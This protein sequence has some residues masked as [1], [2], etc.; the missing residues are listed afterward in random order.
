V[1]ACPNCGRENPEGFRFCGFCSASLISEASETR[2]TVTVVFS[3]VTGSTSLGERLDSESLRRVMSRYFDVARTA[4]ERH[5]GTVEKFI[6]DAVVA[7]F[8]VPEVHEDDALRAARASFEL[9]AALAELNDELDRTWGAHL[10]IRT[11]INTGDVVAGDPSSGQTFVSGDAVNVAARLEQAAQP[12]EIL[13]GAE[14]LRLVRDAVRVDPMEALPL[15]GKSEPVRA[16]RLVEILPGEPAFARR[17]D[18]PM[19]GRDPEL[20]AVLDAFEHAERGRACELVTVLG[21]AGVGKSRLLRE[22]STRLVDRARIL[23]GRCLAYGEGITFWPVA[24]IVKQAARIDDSDAPNEARAKI[25]A[26]FSGQDAEA[27]SLIQERVGAAIGLGETQG[28]VQETFWAFRRFL[29][30]LATERP[31]VAVIDDI[32]W[33]EATLLDL[34]EYVA[35][36]SRG[37]PLLL[38]CTARPELHEVRPE[39]GRTGGILALEPL[40]LEESEQLIENLLGQTRL[41]TEVRRRIVESSEGNPLFVEEM[42]RMLIDDGLLRRDDGHWI[43]TNDLSRVSAPRTIQA[44]IAARL[45]RLQDEERAVAQRASV[46]GR[47][48]YWGAVVHLSPE[49][50][51]A[52]IGGHLQTLLR[53]ELILP[54]PSPFVGEDA[55]RFSHILI[56][57]AAYQ[58]MPKRVRTEMHE[59]FASWLERMTGARVTEYE[60]ILGYHLEQAH[61]YRAE[62]GPLDEHGRLLGERAASLLAA[63]G[64]RALARSDLPASIS[65]LERAIELMPSTDPQRTELLVDLG[66]ASADA[67]AYSKAES[68]LAEA[69]ERSAAANDERMRAHA[70][71][72]RLSLRLLTDPAIDVED[73]EGQA[74]RALQVLEASGDHLGMARAWH[75]LGWTENMRLR[76]TSRAEALE[77]AAEHARRAGARREELEAL[78]FLASPADHGPMP[79]EQALRRLDEILDRS[80]NDQR[81]ESSVLFSVG[82]LEAM[83]GRFEQ[84]RRAAARSVAILEDLGYRPQAEASRGE[85][86]GFIETLAGDLVAAERELRRA[87][88]ALQAMGETGI[89]ST[90]VADLAV[91]LCGLGRFEE[92]GPFIEASRSAAA[93]EDLLSQAQWRVARSRVL[94]SEGRGEDAVELARQAVALLEP[95]DVINFQADTHVQLAQVLVATNRGAEATQALERALSLYEQKG[96]IVSAD[97]A[98]RM[99]ADLRRL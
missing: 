43:P 83:R 96:N 47:V 84:A 69:I 3:D 34:I 91:V 71:L 19:V 54:E 31:V 6:G 49:K 33:A 14:T 56:R 45:D 97:Q 12:D 28:A 82:R 5:G 74:T 78:Y 23:K 15:K 66:I 25:G 98:R 72:V 10:Q 1:S 13:I 17:L 32:H 99:L 26:M 20:R 90:L 94:A 85:S 60:E 40:G 59:R 89:F 4:M 87:C 38:L 64:R 27:A 95:T 30:T 44:L 68:V 46:V 73:A 53:K 75:V 8:G 93:A 21:V 18:S 11:G 67:G 16:F 77:R 92:A 50:T 36:F 48:F 52:T 80:G 9:R 88:E 55:F 42:L 7:V 58:S 86:F 63:C 22:L 57:D 2:K 61:R 70:M 35:G 29:E 51:R 24:E 39:W 79:V 65:L 62:L 41:P 76:T 81:V 37:H